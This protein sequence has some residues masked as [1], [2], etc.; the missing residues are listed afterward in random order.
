MTDATKNPF[1]FSDLSDLPDTLAQRL[2]GPGGSTEYLKLVDV[3]KAGAAR[4]IKTLSAAEI[5]A[6]AIRMDIFGEKVPAEVT[7]RNWLNKAVEAGQLCKPTRQSYG[8]PGTVS[9]V[10]DEDDD[11]ADVAVADVASS[12]AIAPAPA[13]VTETVVAENDDFLN[14]L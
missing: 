5:T 8:L 10:V 9:D 6:V 3:V 4:G 1:D 11:L 12:G 7:V 2:S 13:A 14:D